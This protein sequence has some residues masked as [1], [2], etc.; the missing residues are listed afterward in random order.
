MGA[1]GRSLFAFVGLASWLVLAGSVAAQRMSPELL[2]KLGRLQGGT[3][4]PDGEWV[5][6]SV[7][8]YELAEDKGDSNLFVVPI[9]GGEPRQLTID[10]SSESAVQWVSTSAGVRLFFA[11]KRG[12]DEHTQVWSLNPDDGEMSQVTDYPFSVSNLKVSP[13]A[14]HIAF[15]ANIKLDDTVQDLFE[16]LPL[17]DARIIDDL[18][19]RHWDSWHD[20]KYSHLHVAALNGEGKAEDPVDL[21]EGLKFDCPVPP[22]GGSEQ[23]E[24]APDGREIA[25]TMKVSNRPAVST[26]TDVYLH[27]VP[28]DGSARCITPGMGGYDME[29]VYSPDGRYLTFQSMERAGFESDRN[30][31]MLLDRKSSQVIELTKG[32]DRTTHGVQWS[33]DSRVVYFRSETRGTDQLFALDIATQRVRQITEGQ[34]NW[35]LKQPTPDGSALLVARQSMVRPWEL[36]VIPVEGGEFQVLTDINGEVYDGLELPKVK[37][38]FVQATDGETIHSWV[39][40]PPG[41]DAKKKWPLLVYCQGGPQGQVGQWFSYRWNFHL[42]AAQGYVVIAPNRRGLPGFGR[43]WNDQISGDWSGQAMQ[44]LLACTDDM[45]TESY[46]DPDRVAAVGASFGGYTVFWMMG[47]HEGRF[48][49]MIAHC[50]L[51]NLESFY[52]ATE[53]LFFPN[54]DVGG[55]YWKNDELQKAYD[56]HSPNR[57][58]KNWDTPIL[59]VHGQKDFRVPVTQGM[60]AFTAAR[61]EGIRAR[62]LYYP[63]EGHWVLKPQNGVLWHRIFF[64]W[65][66]RK[67]SVDGGS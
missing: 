64:D 16:D 33:P 66:G 29:P 46:V 23:F 41:F 36:G 9:G 49:T 48:R 53:E 11:S 34:F 65:L 32:L 4:S 40:Y 58:V 14:K 37:S 55:P 6:Y 47:N 27:K 18:M 3:V 30:R 42:M 61:L 12:E 59:I 63:E 19:Y 8:R 39:I 22:F 52:G 10:D 57:Y 26:D 45:M 17:A 1:R 24:W 7:K 15:T 50:G 51:F 44:D 21:M 13:T 35:T 38:R 25:Y 28:M 62:F 54:W 20:Y 31:I 67:M 43:D 60:E 2:W 5:A 56:Q